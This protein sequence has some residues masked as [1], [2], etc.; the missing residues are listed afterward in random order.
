MRKYFLFIFPC[1][2][3]KKNSPYKILLKSLYN[4]IQNSGAD[5]V[6]SRC[7][8][9]ASDYGWQSAFRIVKAIMYSVDGR[10]KD[11]LLLGAYCSLA[12]ARGQLFN[13]AHPRAVEFSQAR[14]A[15][16]DPIRVLRA[17]STRATDKRRKI[18]T[19]VKKTRV[20]P[21][22]RPRDRPV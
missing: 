17:T 16:C 21:G 20:V 7:R 9:R 14:S 8:G 1:S 6:E 3:V 13:Q 11:T 22:R 12:R 15:R 5:V 19:H 18:L 2:R 4:R 10:I